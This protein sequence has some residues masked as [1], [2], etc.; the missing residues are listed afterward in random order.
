MNDNPWHLLPDKPPF[1]LPDDA[2]FVDE[3]NTKAGPK[4]FLHVNEI[5]P[6]AFVGARNAPV[7]L[8]S[9]NPGYSEKGAASKQGPV[10]VARMRNNLLHADSDYPFL[11]LAPDFCGPGKKWWVSKLKQLLDRFGDQVI[12]RSILNVPYF[13]YP[14]RRYDP[15]RR[16]GHGGLRLRSQEYGFRLVQEAVKHNAVVVRMRKRS[17]WLTAVPELNGYDRLY[18]VRNWQNP[19]ISPQNCDN[20]EEVVRAI[21]EWERGAS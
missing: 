19:A 6:E 15:S 13:P 11:F 8:L 10:F 14:S 16:H 20:F 12:A 2:Q 3:F 21:A 1:V 17:P 4:R 9:N 18:R 5:L 7:L